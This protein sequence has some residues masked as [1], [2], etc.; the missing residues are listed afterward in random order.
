MISP[1]QDAPPRYAWQRVVEFSDFPDWATISRRFAPLFAKSATLLVSSPL[2][3]EAKRIAAAHHSSLD[4]ASAALKMVQQEVRYIYVGLD[5][6]NLKPAAAEETWKCRYGDCKGKTAL[7]LGL[8]GETGSRRRPCWSIMLAAMTAWT[9][10]C[11]VR[12]CSTMC[13]YGPGS[14]VPTI[15]STARFRRLPPLA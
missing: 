6:G 1:P 4:R 3:A 2:K 5:G 15:G 9:S 8:L 10:V 11:L 12:K 13:E 14:T 7:L